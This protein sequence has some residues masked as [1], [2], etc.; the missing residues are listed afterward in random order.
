[1]LFTFRLF[2]LKIMNQ[3]L[4]PRQN[5]QQANQQHL[6]QNRQHNMQQNQALQPAYYNMYNGNSNIFNDPFITTS[7]KNDNNVS[8]VLLESY[9]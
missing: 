8:I 5:Q 4:N 2:L 6:L 3:P 9:R 1:P 7:N